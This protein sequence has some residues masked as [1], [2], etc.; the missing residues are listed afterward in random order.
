MVNSKDISA[1]SRFPIYKLLFGY[2]ISLSGSHGRRG[3]G[4]YGDT[5]L[6]KFAALFSRIFRVVAQDVL[7]CKLG[8]YLLKS[9]VELVFVDRRID[10]AAGLPCQLDHPPFGG[11]LAKICAAAADAGAFVVFKIGGLYDVDLAIRDLK[12]PQ[13]LFER[14]FDVAHCIVTVGNYHDNA[15]AFDTR[16]IICGVDN[17]VK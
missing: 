11:E 13:D 5:Y 3:F 16:E 17:T 6:A 14:V 7:L 2:V 10:I 12:C 4:F 9:A 8:R 1:D 15:S